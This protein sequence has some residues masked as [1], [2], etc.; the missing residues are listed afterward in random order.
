MTVGRSVRD[1]PGTPPA[2]AVSSSCQQP[3]P[4]MTVRSSCLPALLV[5]LLPVTT[6]AQVNHSYAGGTNLAG[7]AGPSASYTH[8]F[9]AQGAVGVTLAARWALRVDA[10]VSRFSLHQ[11]LYA[12]PPRVIAPCP[13]YADCSGIAYGSTTPFGIAALN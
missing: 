3:D 4:T 10:L 5:V 12:Y 13:V 8:G 9:S 2:G 1:P 11:T 6:L 7:S